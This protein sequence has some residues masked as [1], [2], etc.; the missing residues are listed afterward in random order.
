MKTI[1]LMLLLASCGKHEMPAAQDLNDND[2]DQIPNAYEKE[3][4]KDIADVEPLEEIEAELEYQ[5]GL[6]KLV[7]HKFILSNKLDL[8]KYS[9][10]LLVKNSLSLISSDYFSEF[11]YLRLKENLNPD[12][13]NEGFFRVVLRSANSKANP[14]ELFLIY[15]DRKISLGKWNS[16]FDFELNSSDLKAILKGEAHIAMSHLNTKVNFWSED[17]EDTI[18][19]KTFRVFMNDG[20]KTAIYYMSKKLNTE[21]VLKYFKI[22]KYKNIEEQN[23]LTTT[24][25]PQSAEWWIRKVSDRD[26]II[27]KDNLRML[28]NH[29][30]E[31]FD[32]KKMTFKRENGKTQSQLTF[33]KHSAA[34][35]LLK[36]RGQQQTVTYFEETRKEYGNHGKERGWECHLSYR[37]ASPITVKDLDPLDIVKSLRLNGI[38]TQS[39]LKLLND[40]TGTFWE[41]EVNSNE[42]I[43]NLSLENLT[44]QEYLQEGLFAKRCTSDSIGEPKVKPNLQVP[45]RSLTLNIEAFV[46]KI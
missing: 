33:N 37:S 29:Y 26:I 5:S 28:S 7:N 15:P 25:K 24:L 45:E 3:G 17:Q 34:R 40:E 44:S 2:G 31:G 14:K 4:M 8:Q 6:T 12:L 36:I 11:S 21:S 46:E 32:K 1:L 38:E 30:L 10:D 41:V 27:V 42:E 23:L 18:R 9:R 43:L 19:A 13:G 20:T 39:E 22:S 35:I 16:T